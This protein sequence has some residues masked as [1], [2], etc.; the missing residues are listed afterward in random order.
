M[1]FSQLSIRT[2]LCLLLTSCSSTPPAPP[3]AIVIQPA[4]ILPETFTKQPSQPANP[5]LH[6]PERVLGVALIDRPKAELR[7]GPG[8]QFQL[9][10][11]LLPHG[12]RVVIIERSSF[13]RRV[14]AP[15]YK[16][17][18]WVHYQ[19]L[20]MVD[21]KDGLMTFDARRL[22][23]VFAVRPIETAYNFGNLS[24]L[25]VTIPKGAGFTKI[26]ERGGKVLVV[27]PETRSL[28]WLAKEDVP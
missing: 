15:E 6:I 10:D 25:K 3:P 20:K 19:T 11:R 1:N 4:S 22:P 7:Q 24:K 26:R 27:V 23:K 14:F 8:F 9:E 16:T 2:L 13:W 18:G 12:T 28:L 17:W 21:E 5:Y